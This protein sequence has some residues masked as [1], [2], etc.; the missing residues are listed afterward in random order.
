ME[1]QESKIHDYRE[2][3]QFID[4]VGGP[5]CQVKRISISILYQLA[6]AVLR[7]NAV[8]RRVTTL[9]HVIP[10]RTSSCDRLFAR[11]GQNLLI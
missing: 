5:R 9:Q 8:R 10:V 1:N 3:I 2:K 6:Y 4:P 11:F 7:Q